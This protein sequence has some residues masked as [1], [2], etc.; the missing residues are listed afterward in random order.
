[1]DI[2]NTPMSSKDRPDLFTIDSPADVNQFQK[3][4]LLMDLSD[5]AAKYDGRSRYSIGPIA[6]PKSTAAS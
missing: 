6:W 3:D 4:G 5:V 1:M 2:I